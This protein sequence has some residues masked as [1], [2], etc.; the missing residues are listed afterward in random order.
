M[1]IFVDMDGVL[2]DFD[3]Y[4]CDT[5]EYGTKENWN[6]NW[7]DI[8]DHIFRDLEKMYDADSLIEYLEFYGNKQILTAIPKGDKV[9][10]ARADKLG[11]MKKHYNINPWDVNVVYR[12]E[13]QIYATN[14]SIAYPNILIDD[15]EL[16]IKEWKERGGIGILHT[17]TKNTISEL[18]VIGF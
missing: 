8:P 15:N 1:I 7:N 12:E 17:S 9:R 11:W 10:Y 16:N 4:I 5:M 2:S 13:K 3:K 6:D 18:N 14:G